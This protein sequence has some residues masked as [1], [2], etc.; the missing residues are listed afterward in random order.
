MPLQSAGLLLYRHTASQPEFLLVHPGGPYY[1]KRDTGVWSIPKGLFDADEEA[2][3]A[4]KREFRE[5]TG[6]AP[7]DGPYLKLTP[8]RMKGGKT[9]YAWAAAGDTDINAICSNTFSMEYPYKSGRYIEVPEVDRAAW[10]GFDAAAGK[11]IPAQL[12][13]LEELRI[14]LEQ[15]H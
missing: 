5:E 2:L 12:P 7:P 6:Q 8:V 11:I 3:V 9:I 13:M 4:A 14:L 15:H 10:L 1:I